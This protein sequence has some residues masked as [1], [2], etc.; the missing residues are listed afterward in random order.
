MASGAK[1]RAFKSRRARLFAL[2]RTRPYGISRMDVTLIPWDF[3]P[4]F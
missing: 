2:C 1:G 4:I 3:N